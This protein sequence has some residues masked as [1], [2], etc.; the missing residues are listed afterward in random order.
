[1]YA[2][3][4]FYNN[5]IYNFDLINPISTPFVSFMYSIGVLLSKL[6]S[7]LFILSELTQLPTL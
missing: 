3:D 1:M 7:L 2:N 6:L 5:F 4:T